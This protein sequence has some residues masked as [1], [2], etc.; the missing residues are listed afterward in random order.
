M[1]RVLTV[2]ESDEYTVADNVIALLR[3]S[4]REIILNTGENVYGPYSLNYVVLFS[5]GV[6]SVIITKLLTDELKTFRS[7][8]NLVTYTTVVEHGNITA[9]D[10][11]PARRAAKILG[12]PHKEAVIRY[13]DLERYVIRT[14]DILIK[15]GVNRFGH[16]R[17]AESKILEWVNVIKVGVGICVLAVAER[18]EKPSHLFSGLGSEELFAGYQR[19]ELTED[20]NEECRRGLSDI[21]DRDLARDRAIAREYGHEI[22]FPFLYRPLI[23]YSLRIPPELKIRNGYKK[24]ILRVGCERIGLPKEIV[25]RKKLAAQYGSGVDRGIRQLAKD[26]GF[27]YKSEYIKHLVKE[28]LSEV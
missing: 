23:D 15:E 9:K 10:R 13:D 6:D 18:I 20:V 25:W 4:V 2:N 21:E 7:A 28:R 12:V 3:K 27:R 14:V 26:S 22:H 24:Y 11:E 8:V 16:L 19:H 5:G 17:N 1:M